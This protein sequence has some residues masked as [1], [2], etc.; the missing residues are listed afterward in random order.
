MACLSTKS[1]Y[2]LKQASR[3]INKTSTAWLEEYGYRQS[4]VD[5]GIHAFCKAGE[6]HVLALHVN[7][8]NTFGSAGSFIANIKTALGMWFNRQDMGPVSWLL[9]MTVE[10]PHHQDWPTAV[11]FGYAT[12]LLHGG[13]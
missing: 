2:G 5:P 10:Q 1:L 11:C 3:N 9:D 4:K 6:L 8:N 13:L 7:D 12:T